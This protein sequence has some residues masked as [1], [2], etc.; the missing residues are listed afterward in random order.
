MENQ[1][2]YLFSHLPT[3]R[4]LSGRLYSQPIVE[5]GWDILG[6]EN[7][8]SKSQKVS[9]DR[10]QPT[11]LTFESGK[12][13]SRK[14][15]GETSVTHVLQRVEDQLEEIGFPTEQRT[16][17]PESPP[18]TPVPKAS[19]PQVP[20]NRIS[21]AIHTHGIVP[22]KDQWDDYLETFLSDVHTLYPFLH[23][24]TVHNMYDRLWS[25]IAPSA[26]MTTS[27]DHCFDQLVQVL[28]MLAIGRCVLSSRVNTSEGLHS[29]GWSLYSTALDLRGNLLDFVG[30]DSRP[31]QTLQTL[32]LMV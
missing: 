9:T 7:P 16:S 31:L 10:D 6:H 17:P 27:T 29:A 15:I 13:G 23:E 2:K 32:V 1:L 28:L 5:G 20:Q 12:F 30:D 22:V 18:M 24:P 26:P 25:I 3:S 14:Y 8:Y 19:H 21:S 4:S 11:G